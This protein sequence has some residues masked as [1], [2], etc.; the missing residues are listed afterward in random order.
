[1]PG[2]ESLLR[3]LYFLTASHIPFSTGSTDSDPLDMLLLSWWEVGKGGGPEPLH[4]GPAFGSPTFLRESGLFKCLT[5]AAT[6][7]LW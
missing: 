2:S 1:M 5:R 3:C 4:R 6:T 7:Q